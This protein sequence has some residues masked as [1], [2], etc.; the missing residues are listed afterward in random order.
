M[1]PT[2]D[3]ASLR[4]PNQKRI[5]PLRICGGEETCHRAALRNAEDI[6]A[7]NSDVVHHGANVIGALLKC[8]HID[9]AI[10][11]T[12]AA[13]IKANETAELAEA[14]E[15][16]GALRYFP[17]EI[18]MRHGAGRPNDVEWSITGDLIGN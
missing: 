15:E 5:N 7:V 2:C 10:G 12:G 13:F 9:R 3:P 1:I 16:K 6:C 11:Q 8:R 18:E 17:I 4:A 14:L